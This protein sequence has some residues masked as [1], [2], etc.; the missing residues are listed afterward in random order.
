MAKILNFFLKSLMSKI[1]T[2]VLIAGLLVGGWYYIQSFGFNLFGLSFGGELKIDNTA[3]VVENIKEISEF[4]TACYYEEAVLK[5]SKVEKHEGGFLG[6]VDTETSKEIVIIAKGK[7]RAG[8]D[9]SKVT[10]DKINIKNDTIGITLP[11]PEIFDVIINPSDYEMYI[12]EGNWSHEE[13]T[14]LQTNYRAQLLAK[15][16]ERG[17]LNKAKEAAKKRLESLFMTFGFTVVELN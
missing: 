8:F 7:V 15:A 14:A 11:E 1:A 3:N 16:Q 17:I 4:T 2:L 13:V 10:E 5:E 12:E 9:L 6:L